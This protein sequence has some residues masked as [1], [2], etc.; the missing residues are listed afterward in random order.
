MKRTT[1]SSAPVNLLFVDTET[2]PID[3]LSQDNL[4]TH[5][6]WFGYAIALRYEKG[7][8][9]REKIC[10]FETPEQFWVFLETR[11][12]ACRPLW[13]FAHN[14]TFDATILDLWYT[15]SKDGWNCDNA[16]TEGPPTFFNLSKDGCNV[17]FVD[18]L[19][20]WRQ[21]LLELGKSVGV[22]KLEMPDKEKS[23]DD[24]NAYCIQDVRILQKA[25]CAFID[26]IVENKL[27]R[28]SITLAGQAMAAYKSR[29]MKQPI[30]IHNR[31]CAIKLERE[32]YH[33]GL[34][35]N[36]YVGEIK[37]TKMFHYDVNSLYPSQML[38]PV[39]V[40][41]LGYRRNVPITDLAKILQKDACV[42]R[43]HLDTT[44]Q[45]Y[46][47][48]Y[49]NRL[50]DV[51]GKF[52]TVLCGAELIH[53]VTHK[54]IK[55]VY[56]CAI[57]EQFP[58]FTDFVNFFWEE[59]MKC[60][61]DK[62]PVRNMM[63]KII[64]NSLYGKFGQRSHSWTELTA[65]TLKD[66]YK[67]AGISF[68]EEYKKGW[69]PEIVGWENVNYRLLDLPTPVKLRNT[70]GTLEYKAPLGEHWES[71]PLIA[72]YITSY[73]RQHMRD[74]IAIVG[75]KNVY[76]TDTDSLFVNEL[77]KK[78]LVESGCIDK[79]KLGYLK[80]EEPADY[81]YF[82]C[83]KDY[84]WGNEATR[85]GISKK[86]KQTGENTFEQLQFEGIRSILKRAKEGRGKQPDPTIVIKKITKTLGR[87][88]NK[89]HTT[90]SGWTI[91]F[92]FNVPFGT[93]TVPDELSPV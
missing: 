68:P 57:Y 83:A 78:R 20:Y 40:R 50:Q 64:M 42:A 59:R 72:S 76:Y 74:L 4:E 85:K 49:R 22:T 11:V 16:V 65:T 15:T 86:A 10:R 14:L 29:F 73:A 90:Q 75:S 9:S 81:A 28:F 34:V 79:S 87:E 48:Y 63:A 62:D 56:E 84:I 55:K 24:W 69:E 26:Y 23:Q 70:M 8:V 47:L 35:S 31:E 46:P 89:G 43:V 38:K 7:K 3:E 33:G 53:A 54:H 71:F 30:Y 91:P 39:P 19:N 44:E 82:H 67:Q 18:T 88:Y 5:K 60:P 32:S 52:P 61:K 45:T 51:Y 13:C 17:K 93:D 1:Q 2:R 37:G 77:G 12:D 80:E 36:F 27:G 92:R 41:L 6:L 58:I 25:V 66:L 21:S